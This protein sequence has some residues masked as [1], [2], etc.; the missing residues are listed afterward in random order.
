MSGG[1]NETASNEKA[2]NEKASNETASNGT[3]SNGTASNGTA[4]NEKALNEKVLNEG[5]NEVKKTRWVQQVQARWGDQR[6]DP[7]I[8]PGLGPEV[9]AVVAHYALTTRERMR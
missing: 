4:L 9:I 5:Q 7:L 1:K 8:R 6:S 2:S 3:A